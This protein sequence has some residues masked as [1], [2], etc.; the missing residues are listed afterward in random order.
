MGGVTKVFLLGQTPV[1]GMA[2]LLAPS[3]HL[4][5]RRGCGRTRAVWS[6]TDECGLLEQIV[7]LTC[8]SSLGHCTM[9]KFSGVILT[10]AYSALEY[11]NELSTVR[12]WLNSRA[13]F[14]R[15]V[16][17][18]FTLAQGGNVGYIFRLVTNHFLNFCIELFIFIS[19]SSIQNSLKS[20]SCRQFLLRQDLAESLISPAHC[21][22]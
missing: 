12:C 8:S 5:Y 19:S 10:T 18:V 3:T 4:L 13:S 15:T 14:T 2:P 9:G 22:V 6:H 7:F 17:N 20:I 16:F 11:S 1:L 21:H